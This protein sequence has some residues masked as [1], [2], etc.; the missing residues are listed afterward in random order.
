MCNNCLQ[1]QFIVDSQ[2]SMYKCNHANSCNFYLCKQCLQLNNAIKNNCKNQKNN[3]NSNSNDNIKTNDNIIK[4]VDN[5]TLTSKKEKLFRVN[6]RLNNAIKN[7]DILRLGCGCAFR[8]RLV[9]PARCV[10]RI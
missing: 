4:Y 7:S 2:K 6:K 3:G 8:Y 5:E 9:S 10:L 1:S